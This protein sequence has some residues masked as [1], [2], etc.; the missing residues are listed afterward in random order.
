MSIYFILHLHITY[1]FDL[2]YFTAIWPK[3]GKFKKTK[4]NFFFLYEMQICAYL[5]NQ[6][7]QRANC[8]NVCGATFCKGATHKVRLLKKANFLLI[9]S[10][11]CTHFKKKK[12]N[13]GTETIDYRFDQTSPSVFLSPAYV[14]F[15]WSLIWECQQFCLFC[16]IKVTQDAW[17]VKFQIQRCTLD[18]IVKWTINCNVKCIFFFTFFCNVFCFLK[19]DLRCT[20]KCNIE[21]LLKFNFCWIVLWTLFVNKS[22]T[23]CIFKCNSVAT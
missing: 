20:F 14:P 9:P 22:T 12:K 8:R 17:K 11:S 5:L 19:W 3:R 23:M 21:C 7:K 4:R 1:T 2:Y 6:Q 10:P 16:S 13:G 15:W 18:Y